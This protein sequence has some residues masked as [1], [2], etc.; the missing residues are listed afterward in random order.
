MT[1]KLKH[2]LILTLSALFLALT[3]FALVSSSQSKVNAD[4]DIP[5]IPTEQKTKY[6]EIDL[7]ADDYYAFTVNPS[8]PIGELLAGYVSKY[9]CEE[10]KVFS[11]YWSTSDSEIKPYAIKNETYLDLVEI[12]ELKGNEM[13]TDIWYSLNFYPIFIDSSAEISVTF[14][15]RLEN[16]ETNFFSFT[17]TGKWDEEIYYD[18]L[19]KLDTFGYSYRFAKKAETIDSLSIVLRDF[20]GKTYFEV[21]NAGPYSGSEFVGVCQ[22]IDWISIY[23]KRAGKIITTRTIVRGETLSGAD[24][25]GDCAR[26]GYNLLG[27][28]LT[29]NGEIVYSAD[30]DITPDDDMTLYAVY[31]KIETPDNTVTDKSDDSTGIGDKISDVADNV[32]NWLK[33]NT[34][35][36]FSSGSLI[37]IAI[38]LAVVMLSKRK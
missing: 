25:K 16:I 10:G 30:E 22:S 5:I 31:E 23:F 1:K 6:Y 3:G 14:D 13:S 35:V 33:D 18:L 38:V 15:I 11:G 28:S 7:I 36:V 12:M 21:A 27:Y 32:S 4:D 8:K 26:E 37:I 17:C 34:G 19:A 29:E 9:E 2:T 24:L 20:V